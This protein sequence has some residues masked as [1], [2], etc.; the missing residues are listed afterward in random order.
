MCNSKT[1]NLTVLLQNHQWLLTAG[2][3]VTSYKSFEARKKQLV[4]DSL[5]AVSAFVTKENQN[6]TFK[7]IT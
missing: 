7:I 3:N 1:A 4:L 6:I 2:T 5:T